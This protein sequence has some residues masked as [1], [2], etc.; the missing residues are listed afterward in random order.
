MPTVP[1]LCKRDH[2]LSYH[3]I[4][5]VGSRHKTFVDRLATSLRYG[6]SESMTWKQQCTIE[7]DG[8]TRS[9]CEP[10]KINTVSTSRP[11]FHARVFS[12]V[13]SKGTGTFVLVPTSAVPEVLWQGSRG[14]DYQSISCVTCVTSSRNFTRQYHC[15]NPSMWEIVH[16]YA[17]SWPWNWGV[18]LPITIM[19]YNWMIYSHLRFHNK[20]TDHIHSRSCQLRQSLLTWWSGL[21]GTL[22]TNWSWPKGLGCSKHIYW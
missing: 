20:L 4:T 13:F 17:N 22:T 8:R 5:N 19:K 15:E 10:T 18:R 2:T 9:G 3:I 16:F 21:R 12:R 11:Q 1:F 14:I 7:K 6:S